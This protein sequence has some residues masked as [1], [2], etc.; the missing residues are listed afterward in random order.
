MTVCIMLEVPSQHQRVGEI[1]GR[2][3]GRVEVSMGILERVLPPS[4]C[5]AGWASYGDCG[6]ALPVIADHGSDRG[7]RTFH[8]ARV[9]GGDEVTKGTQSG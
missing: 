5:R 3:C 1:D 9:D 6:V 8:A 4:W 7:I 2:S